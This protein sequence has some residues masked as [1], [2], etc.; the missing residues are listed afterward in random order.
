MADQGLER[1][2]THAAGVEGVVVRDLGSLVVEED[3]AVRL[4]EGERDL[5]VPFVGAVADAQ[6]A[7]ATQAVVEEVEV[8]ALVEV[9]FGA[10]RMCVVVFGPDVPEYLFSDH[11]APSCEFRTVPAS[12]RADCSTA[13]Q[14]PN[15]ARRQRTDYGAA[16]LE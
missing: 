14:C 11:W 2:E 13:V 5:G 16:S 1:L 4:E 9:L 10:E 15:C 6:E 8:H 3:A 12:R 7:A